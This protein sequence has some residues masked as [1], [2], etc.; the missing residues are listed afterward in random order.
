MAPVLAFI[1]VGVQNPVDGIHLVPPT[2]GDR[3]M[4][5]ALWILQV[6]VGAFFVYHAT[7]LLRP[8]PERLRQRMKWI[9]EM[10]SGLRVFAGVAEGLAGIALIFA[11]LIGPVDWLAP[12]AAAGLVLLMI[13]AIVFHLSRREYPNIAL[14]AVLLLLSAF[15]AYGRFVVQ[16]FDA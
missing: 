6:V 13:G 9:L 12:M 15:I 3:V 11:G 7:L 5:I 8:N 14:N 4:N 2:R 16:R 1:P 10:P